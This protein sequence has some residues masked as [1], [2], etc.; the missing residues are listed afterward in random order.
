RARVR[1]ARGGAARGRR[2]GAAPASGGGDGPALGCVARRARH[3]RPR[4]LQARR[5]RGHSRH[6]GRDFQGAPVARAGIGPPADE[7]PGDGGLGMKPEEPLDAA[8]RDALRQADEPP[9]TPREAMWAR[10]EAERRRRRITALETRRLP[11]SA[12][13]GIA[14]AAIL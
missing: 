11:A 7:R 3:A 9:A 6:P 5:N 4:R 14:A 10:I 13:L 2:S 1:R 8:L 12:W